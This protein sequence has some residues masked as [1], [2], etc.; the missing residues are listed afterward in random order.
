MPRVRVDA[1]Y[2][3]SKAGLRL[4]L[5]IVLIV[6]VLFLPAGRRASA[7]AVAGDVAELV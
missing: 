6:L 4:I 3:F 7:T 2:R 1:G 5:T